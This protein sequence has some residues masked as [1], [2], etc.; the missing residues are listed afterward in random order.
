MAGVWRPLRDIS[1]GLVTAVR[2]WGL[3]LHRTAAAVRRAR[4]ADAPML[5]GDP[6]DDRLADTMR[7]NWSG[8]AHHGVDGLDSPSLRFG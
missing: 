7:R 5:G 8:F 6:V 3:P 1:G 4:W 2:R